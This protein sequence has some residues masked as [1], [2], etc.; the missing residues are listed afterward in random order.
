MGIQLTVRRM[1]AVSIV[2]AAALALS[3]CLITPGKFVATMDLRKDGSFGFTYRGEIYMLALSKLAQMAD[4]ADAA[5]AEFTEQECYDDDLN[6]RKCSPDEL[7][8]QRSNWE[9]EQVRKRE[10]A[11]KERESMQAMLGG[12]DPADPA[13]AEEVAERLR[14]Q[15]GW[16]TVTYK[17]DGLYEVDFA[18]AS[19]ASHD[20]AFPSI[21]GFPMTNPFVLATMRQGHKVRVTAPGFSAQ[22]GN[23]PMAGMMGGMA[24]AMGGM[25]AA[26]KDGLPSGIPAIEGTFR[27]TTDGA[28]LANNTEEGPVAGTTGQV[29]EWAISRRTEAAPMALVD[30]TRN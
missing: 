15:E 2:L 27:L 5:N 10:N 22:S 4:E 8:E 29:M 28:I 13:A 25:A 14:R 7:A 9:A 17:G 18:I 1:A 3:A 19:R 11:Q 12:I 24:G 16:R 21:E 30:L 20:F 26:E 6:E 23:N